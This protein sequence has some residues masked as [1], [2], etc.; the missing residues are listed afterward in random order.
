M[1]NSSLF[2]S[3]GM[4]HIPVAWQ[5]PGWNIH[6]NI[7]LSSDI[8]ALWAECHTSPCLYSSLHH[9][10]KDGNETIPFT[11][12]SYAGQIDLQGHD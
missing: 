8:S 3:A 10:V 12:D 11:K 1:N 2:V 7:H 4:S 6:T 5:R 9:Q